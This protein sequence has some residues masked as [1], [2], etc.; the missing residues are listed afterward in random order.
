MNTLQLNAYETVQWLKKGWEKIND[1]VHDNERL[2]QT[3][4]SQAILHDRTIERSTTYR[5]KND[6]A[7]IVFI[8]YGI[9]SRH[10][11]HNLFNKFAA[12]ANTAQWQYNKQIN[13]PYQ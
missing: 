3:M 11:I 1:N 4:E 10:T 9:S 12:H 6:F 13:K 8:H 2:H 5:N 7:Q